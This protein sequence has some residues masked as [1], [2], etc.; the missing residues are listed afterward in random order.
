MYFVEQLINGLSQ[1]AIYALMAIGFTLI[2]GEVGLVSFTYGDTVML[3][4]F[5]LAILLWFYVLGYD[6]G[7]IPDSSRLGKGGKSS[8]DGLPC[9]RDGS[10]GT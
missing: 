9:H 5:V 10:G 8:R 2:A 1:G 3:G 7:V 6:T 4:A